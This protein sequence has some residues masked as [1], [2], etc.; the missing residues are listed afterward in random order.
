[1]A[2]TKKKSVPSAQDLDR[3]ALEYHRKHPKGKLA[4]KATK[5][6]ETQYDL[7]LAYSPGVA[8]ACREIESNALMAREYTAKGNLIGVISNGTAVLGLGNIGALAS[9]PVMEGKAVLFKKFA[10]IDVF[11]IEVNET[12]IDKFCDIVASMEPTFG[13]I[14]LEDIKAPECFEIEK[15][16]RERMKI[17][18]FHD[19]QHGTAIIV[20]AAVYNGLKLVKKKFGNVKIVCSGAGAAA[21]ACLNMLIA[22]GAKRKNITVCDANGV[23]YEGRKERM[24]KYKGAF[25]QK[26]KHRKLGE[27]LKGADIFLGLS[28][29]GVLSGAMVKGMAKDP[30]IFAL[31]NPIPEIMP[32][33]AKVARKDALIGTGRSDYPNQ[34]NNVLCFPFIF[35]GALD[36]GATTINEEMKV[37]CAL[38]IASLAHKESNDVV[39]QAYTGEELKFG[40]EYLIPK[41][42][43]PRL[44]VEIAPAV[45]KAAMDSGIATRPIKDLE[46]YKDS[47]SNLVYKSGSVMSPVF[48]AAS[49][50]IKR[51]AFAEGEEEKIL[52]AVQAVVDE[53]LAFPVL[54][55]RKRVV[56][57]RIE[58]LGLRLKAGKDYELCDPE[59]DD[60]FKDYWQMYHK[61]MGRSGASPERAKTVVRTRT[62]VIGALM[63]KR[64]EADAFIC[65]TIGAFDRHLA[66][67]RDIVGLKAGVRDYHT[68]NIL[69]T[70]HDSLFLA[71]THV[72]KDPDAEELAEIGLET[73]QLCEKFGLEPRIAMLSHSNFGSSSSSNAVKVKQ[74][75][76]IMQKQAPSLQVDGEMHADTALDESLRQEFIAE[77]RL[78][79]SAN[80]LVMPNLD[81]A[82]IAYN[83]A[84]MT[85]SDGFS[86]GPYLSGAALPVHVLTTAVS[87][88]GIVNMV[89]LAAVDAQSAKRGAKKGAK[90]K[91]S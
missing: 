65:G 88:R 8:A 26:T 2:T 82:N 51:V 19:D 41:P 29:P 71:D 25:A 75:V 85:A 58:K 70:E 21:I 10:N 18:V 69:L 16:L 45:A 79:G 61:M 38:A 42:F 1:M 76:E 81:A 7:A 12:D 83:L 84:K 47:L 80:I 50:D 44:I 27:A 73:A 87:V 28:A 37:A 6:M 90:R 35:R 20:A 31:A 78:Q 48:E 86:I 24:D 72:S 91:K 11:D 64:G 23:V 32:E 17:P 68:V 56:E 14:N 59:N 22:M 36:V 5:P 9:K 3:D 30:L 77:S 43:D 62:T 57:S 33:E 39:A 46:A 53:S 13:G 60:R 89:A 4:I 67:I 66:H 52:R 15:R 74:A 54:I 40:P 34:I 49:N 55:G 63:L